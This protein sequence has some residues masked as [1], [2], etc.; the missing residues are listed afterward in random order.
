MNVRKIREDL[1][2]AKASCQRKDLSRALFLLVACL[3]DL[4]GQQA[5]TDLRSDFRNL[6]ADIGK[7]PQYKKISGKAVSYQPG[8]EKEL[9]VFYRNLYS[10]LQGQG[11]T[12][13]YDT[14]LKR[15]LNL[16]HA[17][18]EGK[19]LLSQ[20]KI[21][22]A[23]AAFAKA[24]TFYKNEY[25]AFAMM[26]RALME[27][28]E[29]VRALGHLRKGLK[30]HPNDAAMKRLAEECQNKR[31]KSDL[32]GQMTA[33][34]AAPA[35]AGARP[36]QANPAAVRPAAPAQAGQRPAPV[37]PASPRPVVQVAKPAPK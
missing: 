31:P 27:V 33:R 3:K 5:P 6:I 8:K 29:Y 32:P 20:G 26:A 16:D 17:I 9:L 18:S 12:E 13:D 36:A 28:G 2:K 10:E 11:S 7:D 4:G 30:D 22:E 23:D 21:S 37:N 19:Q 15:K 34:P 14:A 24:A 35:A 25:Q 1:G